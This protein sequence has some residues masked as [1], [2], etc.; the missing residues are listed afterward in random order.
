MNRLGMRVEAHWIGWA[1][2]RRR[3]G[4]AGQARGGALGWMSVTMDFR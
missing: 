2:S 1:C 4:S 3:M